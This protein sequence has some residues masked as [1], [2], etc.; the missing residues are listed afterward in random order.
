MLFEQ[1]RE[2]QKCLTTDRKK[3]IAAENEAIEVER[4]RRIQQARVGRVIPEPDVN[5]VT[6]K[7]RHLSVGLCSRRFPSDAKMSAVYD[8]VGS[9]CPEPENFILF[10]PLGVTF[11]PSTRLSD[12]TISMVRASE[13]PSISDSDAEIEFQGF[14]T[15]ASFCSAATSPDLDKN[16]EADGRRNNEGEISE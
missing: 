13:T 1:R 8:W 10:D 9:L 7:V 15:T 6:V 4:K 3:R 16:K 5:F 11:Y 12:S 14:G 2:F